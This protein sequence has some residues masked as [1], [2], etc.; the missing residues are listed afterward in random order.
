MASRFTNL[1]PNGYPTGTTVKQPSSYAII[2]GTDVYSQSSGGFANNALGG[3][4][5]RSIRQADRVIRADVENGTGFT[6]IPIFLLD[7]TDVDVTVDDNG[8][9][10]DG[11]NGTTLPFTI[12]ATFYVVD[13]ST[14]LLTGT[15]LVCGGREFDGAK[16]QPQ[17]LTFR[18]QTFTAATIT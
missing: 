6:A 5:I 4:I 11:G 13:M 18:A 8:T 16:R 1:Y 17:G 7:G 12:G 3:A 15:K 10:G 9:Y 2:L 14:G